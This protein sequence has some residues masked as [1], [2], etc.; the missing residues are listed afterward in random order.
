[1][2]TSSLGPVQRQ[3]M[4]TLQVQLVVPLQAVPV[5]LRHTSPVQQPLPDEQAWPAEE[6][7]APGWQVLAPSAPVAHCRPAQQSAPAVQAPF[8]GWQT[9]GASQV[10]A[11]QMPE[12]QSVP[13]LQPLVPF[14]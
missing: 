8:C 2:R 4:T 1:M 9:A 6:Q 12:Q 14:A 10:P 7:V 13:T 5:P 11:L 3:S